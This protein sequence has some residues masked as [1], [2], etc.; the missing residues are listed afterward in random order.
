MRVRLAYGLAHGYNAIWL[1]DEEKGK[2]IQKKNYN[3]T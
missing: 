3:K 2:C 1:A